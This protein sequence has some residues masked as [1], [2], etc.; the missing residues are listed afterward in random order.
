VAFPTGGH[1]LVGHEDEVRAQI[2]EFLKE[3]AATK[4]A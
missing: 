2:M 1:L 4:A 3:T